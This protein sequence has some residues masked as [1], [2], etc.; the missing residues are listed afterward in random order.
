MHGHPLAG[1]HTFH[2]FSVKKSAGFGRLCAPPAVN[3][4]YEYIRI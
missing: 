3:S 4:A 2:L 1:G